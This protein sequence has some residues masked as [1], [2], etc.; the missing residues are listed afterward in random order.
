MPA[1][2]LVESLLDGTVLHRPN[3]RKAPMLFRKHARVR[4]I[5]AM[6][7]V[8]LAALITGPT[9]EAQRPSDAYFELGGMWCGRYDID[10]G[11]ARMAVLA[12][13]ANLHMTVLQEG[14]YPYG[15]FVDTKTADNYEARIA[16]QPLG[17]F[18]PGTQVGVRITGFGTHRQVC[19]RIL[20]EVSRQMDAARRAPPPPPVVIFPAP[21]VIKGQ[22]PVIILPPGSPVPPPSATV[23]PSSKLLL[24]SPAIPPPNSTAPSSS[25]TVPPDS[26]LLAQPVPLK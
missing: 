1:I 14:F 20:D 19:A 7:L 4:L 25:P 8:L 10:S 11:R 18:G 9:L 3:A 6:G 17:A 22:V 16:V 13:L 21:A 15:S 26:P 23:Q 12:A 2:E 24:P 5:A